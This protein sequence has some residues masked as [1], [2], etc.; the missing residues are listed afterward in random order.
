MT[1]NLSVFPSPENFR[2]GDT[3]LAGAG[4][5][6]ALLAEDGSTLRAEDGSTLLPE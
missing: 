4:S 5:G 1:S 3:D 6:T 2:V